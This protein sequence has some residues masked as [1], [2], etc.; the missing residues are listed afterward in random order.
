MISSRGAKKMWCVVELDEESIGRMEDI[1]AVSEKPVSKREPVVCI[2]EKPLVLHADL[3]P[4]LAKRPGRQLR[5]DS[6]YERRTAKT[7]CS[8]ESK[9]GVTSPRLLRIALRL[10]SRTIRW[11]W[12]EHYLPADTIRPVTDNPSSHTRKEL[13]ERFGKQVGRWL[14][15][16]STV[17][18]T[19]A[20]QQLAEPGGNRNQAVQAAMS[21][22]R[23]IPLLGDLQCDA[24]AWN[25][26]MNRDRVTIN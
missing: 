25:L 13:L 18:Y 23:R 4:P 1:L 12:A 10:S 9:T 22:H 8:V 6:E 15:D 3:H 16:R 17:Y 14:C 21:G 5:R 24:R 7:F 11:R 20:Q 26:R 2:N 19:P